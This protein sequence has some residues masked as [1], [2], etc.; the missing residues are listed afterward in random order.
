MTLVV[1]N[2]SSI[3]N[4]QNQQKC[5]PTG[6]SQLLPEKKRV[7]LLA[8]RRDSNQGGSPVATAIQ[9][10]NGTDSSSLTILALQ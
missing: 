6:N 2:V 10:Q 7:S 4:R 8:G 1:R 9:R 3:A 5:G